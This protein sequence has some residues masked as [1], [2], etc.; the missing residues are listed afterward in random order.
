MC[1]AR[2]KPLYEA[3]AKER[4]KLSEGRGQKGKANLPDLKDASRARDAAGKAFGVGG[5]FM[6]ALAKTTRVS[7]FKSDTRVRFGWS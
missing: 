5:R 2:A 6:N 1:A 4:Q 3:Q 7:F